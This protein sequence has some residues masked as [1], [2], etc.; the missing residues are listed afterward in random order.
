MALV[1]CGECGTEVSDKA[2]TCVRCGA[3]IKKE[4]SRKAAWITLGV[5][6]VCGLVAFL[7]ATA[8]N[9][10]GGAPPASAES[11]SA[12][13]TSSGC[14]KTDL[15]CLGDKGAVGASVY[16]ADQVAKLAKYDVKWTDGT[17]ELKFRRFRWADQ[18]A[19]V[20]TYIGD[21]AMFQNGFGA[22][23]PVVY[24]CDLA[25]DNKTVLDVRV[26]EGRLP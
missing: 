18:A 21:K 7:V 26:R 10:D 24:E 1:K 4:L 5:V 25:P 17:F 11:S 20:I 15:Q 16:C 13:V 2:Q 8:P 9:Q 22:Y 23:T 12:K 6:C 19:G 3:P 14:A